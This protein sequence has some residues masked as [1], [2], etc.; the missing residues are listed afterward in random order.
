MLYNKSLETVSQIC[1]DTNFDNVD[2]KFP[3]KFNIIADALSVFVN[4]RKDMEDNISGYIYKLDE[5]VD[6]NY[7]ADINFNHVLTRVRFT[8][9]HELGHLVKH[10]DYLDLHGRIM[11]RANHGG[12]S[13]EE[14]KREKEA[15]QFASELLMP[16][17]YFNNEYNRLI[18]NKN[19]SVE[20][21][22]SHLS[23]YFWVSTKAIE[24]RI[25]SLGLDRG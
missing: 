5:N 22:I 14:L 19:F 24:Y 12:Y 7:Q 21:I 18:S 2:D 15:N 20:K 11:E 8:V 10:K 9:A 1:T 16:E 23:D 6:Y 13:I 3:V 4:L 17:Y 25:I